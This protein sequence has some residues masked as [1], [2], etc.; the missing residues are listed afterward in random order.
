MKTYSLTNPLMHGPDLKPLQKALKAD[1]FY[2]GPIDGIFG[3]GTGDACKTAKKH[4]GYP[5]AAC[6]ETGGQTLLDYLNGTKPLPVAY[7]LR[8][9]ARGYGVTVEERQRA[10]IVKWARWGIDHEPEIRYA[11]IRPIPHTAQLPLTTDCSGFVTLCFQLAGAPDPNGLRYNGQ[12]W[13]GTLLSHLQTI[14]LWQAKPADLVVWGW[15]P[16]HHTAILLESGVDPLIASHG[17]ENGPL[18]ER[19]SV[20]TAAQRRNYVIKRYAR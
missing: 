6:V 14:P 17:A 7:K 19:L 4:L 15:Y 11:Q 9:R 12:G 2:G 16:G 13:T 18:L 10:A 8:R 20:E 1:K 5:L 3:A